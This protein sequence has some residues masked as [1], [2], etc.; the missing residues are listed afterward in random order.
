MSVYEYIVGDHTCDNGMPGVSWQGNC[1]S[2][3]CGKCGGDDCGSRGE[4]LHGT[5]TCVRE[6]LSYDTCAS[7]CGTSLHWVYGN[8][9]S[10]LVS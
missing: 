4:G 3:G 6:L 10:V 2:L 5:G 7:V 9:R 1:C 8:A